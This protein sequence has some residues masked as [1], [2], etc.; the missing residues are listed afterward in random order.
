MHLQNITK[1]II[2]EKKS[3]NPRNI[4]CSLEIESALESKRL[5]N[6]E[7]SQSL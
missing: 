1:D 6:Y 4:E 5:K 3:F 7:G 2:V